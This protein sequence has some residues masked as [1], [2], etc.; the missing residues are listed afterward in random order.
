MCGRFFVVSKKDEIEARFEV[1]V[2]SDYKENYNAAPMQTVYIIKQPH[3]VVHARWGFKTEKSLVINARVE[4]ITQRA[5]FKDAVKNRRC[6]IIA[7]GF[8][9]WKHE[10][11]FKLTYS[12]ENLITFAGIWEQELKDGVLHLTFVILT[13]DAVGEMKKYHDRMPIVLS[14]NIENDWLTHGD[15]EAIVSQSLVPS[16]FVLLDK[17]INFVKNNDASVLKTVTQLSF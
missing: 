11:P 4:T 3:E 8:I 15:V 16:K 17:K 10:I 6:L 1:E 7:N 12:Q 9:E 14:R 13:T 2:P 5:L